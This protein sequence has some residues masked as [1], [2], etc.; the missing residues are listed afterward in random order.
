MIEKKM[1]LIE[2]GEIKPDSLMEGWTEKQITQDMEQVNYFLFLFLYY[3][4][5]I[6][7]PQTAAEKGWILINSDI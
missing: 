2:N 5:Y 3:F 1:K 7:V 4:S 6:K